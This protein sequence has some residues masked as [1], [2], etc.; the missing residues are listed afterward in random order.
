MVLS[1]KSQGLLSRLIVRRISGTDSYELVAGG[2][3][4]RAARKA[5]LA[6]VPVIVKKL[7]DD[8]A[9]EIAIT[10]NLQRED[11]NPL[12]ETEGILRLLSSRLDIPSIEIP[13]LLVKMYN[14]SKRKEES[15][16]KRFIH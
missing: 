12:E 11:L 3:R 14:D 5:G 1:I 7:T 4:F 2:R 13:S 9:L 16:Q 10:E 6:E 15:E 8:E